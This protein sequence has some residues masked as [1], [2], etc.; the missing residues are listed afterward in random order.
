[1]TDDQPT[2]WLTDDEWKE[3]A[4]VYH[5]Q[6]GAG[7]LLSRAGLAVEKHPRAGNSEK[8]WEAVNELLRSFV[9]PGA[10]RRI[11]A[12]A[13]DAFPGNPT[14]RAG[15]SA[16]RA[17]ENT[18]PAAV[19]V[20]A[21][22]ADSGQG[23]A[24]ASAGPAPAAAAGAATAAPTAG[25]G[26]LKPPRVFISY[27]RESEA[28]SEEVFRLY[29]VLRASGVDAVIDRV[30][31]A[32][33]QDW[34]LWM[35]E[36]LQLA[37]FIVVVASDEYKL[38][39]E[40][41]VPPDR[42]RGLQQETSI[43]RGMLTG[44]H[45]R[46]T[47]RIL[48]VL[49][50]GHRWEEIPLWL[51]APATGYFQV[52]PADAAGFDMLLRVLLAQPYYVEPPLGSRPHLGTRY[53]AAGVATTSGA[54]AA[55]PV[56]AGSAAAAGQ[57]PTKE[58]FLVSAAGDDD[59]WGA[60]IAGV[61]IADGMAVRYLPWETVPGANVIEALEDAVS[62]S[63]KTIA[64][65]SPAFLASSE[66][67]APWQLAWSKDPN[68]VRRSLIPVR[69]VDCKPEGLLRNISSIDLVDLGAEDAKD[70]LLRKLHDALRGHARPATAPKFPGR[71]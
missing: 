41:R 63:T 69:V 70:L 3:L 31:E 33:R 12:I 37:D 64:V 62:T 16:A 42:G 2:E 71:R 8:F 59:D 49:L 48:P 54:A 35:T 1:M 11:L 45:A 15:L 58:M 43:I 5:E 65:L 10:R 34:T 39:A 13:A 18:G 68:G 47:E 26:G 40:G 22:S 30:N 53:E 56:G 21:P 9:L 32:R 44:N 46:W 61:L 66:V 24:A 38:R 28:H 60:W 52:N 51:G 36:E 25:A 27:A 50:P 23:P 67:Q 7:H 6:L 14:F 57:G 20:A 4:R 19:A 55:S 29:E 17:A